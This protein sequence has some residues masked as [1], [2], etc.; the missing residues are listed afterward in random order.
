MLPGYPLV[1][2]TNSLDGV[3]LTNSITATSIMPSSA[4]GTLPGGALQVGSQ[5]KVTLRG[6]ISTVV[7][8]PGT[9]TLDVRFGATVVSAFGAIS[10]NVNAQTNTT[11]ES[12]LIGVV[13]SV[14]SGT[15]ATVLFTGSFMS[16]AV[17]GSA[18]STAG[19]ANETLLPDTA[20]AVGT[21]FDSTNAIAVNVF[22]TWSVASASN[23]IQIHQAIV[24]LKV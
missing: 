2:A 19:G 7:T 13:R 1:L 11:W 15:A 23:S 21:G 6:R 5:I 16:R 14:G 12:V 3:A 22:G 10:L 24:E 20:P 8:T 9:L 18:A 17:I 4:I